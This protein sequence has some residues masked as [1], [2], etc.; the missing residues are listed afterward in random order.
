MVCINIYKVIE[1]VTKNWILLNL[2]VFYSVVGSSG[3]TFMFDKFR[4]DALL[5]AQKYQGKISIYDYMP[6]IREK[7][8]EYYKMYRATLTPWDFDIL[9]ATQTSDK[10]AIL[11]HLYVEDVIIDDVTRY[12]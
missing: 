9:F 3:S 7:I 8:R 2:E 4:E 5:L 1:N 12:K 6:E 11:K 10:G